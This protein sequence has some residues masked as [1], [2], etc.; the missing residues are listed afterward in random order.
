MNQRHFDSLSPSSQIS[1]EAEAKRNGVSK[2]AWVGLYERAVDCTFLRACLAMVEMG[3]PFPEAAARVLCA[4]S[5]ANRETA[6][7]YIKALETQSF[8]TVVIPK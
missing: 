5:D 3:T 1:V 8:A 2:E 7:Q 4:L 6:R